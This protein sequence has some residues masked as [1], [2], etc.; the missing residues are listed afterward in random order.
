MRRE[1]CDSVCNMYYISRFRYAVDV[2]LLE[3][4]PQEGAISARKT[5]DISDMCPRE[6]KR[7][8]AQGASG[9]D[10]RAT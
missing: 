9:E 3:Y 10:R 4:L 5:N 7:Q 6:K 2:C 8:S 1:I